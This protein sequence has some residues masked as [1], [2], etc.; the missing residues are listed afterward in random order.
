[1]S[2]NLSQM[3]FSKNVG[4]QMFFGKM[5]VDQIVLNQ[6][7][8]NDLC[9]IFAQNQIAIIQQHILDTNAGKQQS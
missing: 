7:K 4:D 6:K 1:V 8:S 3:P 9:I 5:S 2:K